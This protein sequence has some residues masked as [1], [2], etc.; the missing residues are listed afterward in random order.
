MLFTDAQLPAGALITSTRT[1]PGRSRTMRSYGVIER[2]FGKRPIVNATKS[3]IGHTVGAAGAIEAAVCALSIRDQRSTVAVPDQPCPRPQFCVHGEGQ[4]RERCRFAIV[5]VR[6]PQRGAA[7][8]K[9]R[10]SGR[11]SIPE[12]SGQQPIVN[13]RRFGKDLFPESFIETDRF[14]AHARQWP[15]LPSHEA[16]EQPR[17]TISSRN[18]VKLLLSM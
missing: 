9:T 12:R 16:G 14:S 15:H 5:R 7:Y 17:V 1:A 11:R 4:C 2:M 10:L 8:L 6:R 18:P 13:H 3:L